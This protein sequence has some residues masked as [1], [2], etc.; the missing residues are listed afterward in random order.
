MPPSEPFLDLLATIWAYP[1]PFLDLLATT[2]AYVG[3]KVPPTRAVGP[4]WGVLDPIWVSAGGKLP[5]F[6]LL[7]I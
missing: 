7:A 4:V 6:R 3:G 1:E 5:P 2:W